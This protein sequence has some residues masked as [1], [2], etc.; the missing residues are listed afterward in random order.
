MKREAEWLEVRKGG[1]FEGIAKRYGILPMTARLIVNRS[2]ADDGG[3][4][5]YLHGTKL[6]DPHR[7]KDMDK[8]VAL[9]REKIRAGK[10]I[11]IIGDYDIDGIN[12]TY[13]LLKGLRRVGG[14]CDTAIPD[15][16][17][18][19]YG[20]NE[21]LM[22]AA[23][24]EGIDTI[25]TCDNGISAADAVRHGKELGLT[26]IVTDHHDIPYVMAAGE[27]SFRLP[28]A[29]AVV[30]PKQ[31]DCPY[32]Y[33]GLCGAVVAWKLVQVLYEAFGIPQAEADVFYENA[34]FATIGDVMDLT[35]ENR[36]IVREG[37]KALRSTVNPGMKALILQSGIAPERIGTYHVGFILGPCINA[38][39]R[40]DTAGRSLALL[41]SENE[42]EAAR[43]AAD[44]V[45]LNE[46][47]KEMTR[48]GVL[49]A[50]ELI[51]REKLLSEKVLVVYLPDCHESLAGI[52][53]GRLRE[54]YHRPVFVLTRGEDGIK[55]SG[56]SIEEYSM[57]D[58]L[59]GVSDLL[60][61]Y[62][63]HPMA[64]GLSMQEE[65]LPAFIRRINETC[66]LTQDDLREKKRF[67]MVLPFRCVSER[68]VQ[69]I[70]L[71]EPF[72]KGNAK[73]LFAARDVYIRS[74]RVLGKNGN[75]LK[76]LLEEGG[77]QLDG[78]YFGDPEVFFSRCNEKERVSILYYPELNEFRGTVRMQA[79]ISDVR[80]T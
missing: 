8:A 30:N 40:L 33:R 67:D 28:P 11:R 53:A 60:L 27:K 44:L 80:G 31:S 49:E 46:S 61:K 73:P 2:V 17:K 10:R 15:R 13:I 14:D 50:E 25:V 23:A 68:F 9:L 54:S 66:R 48:R 24:A 12:A 20:I 51:Q 70:A 64:A 52:I 1:D 47:R 34:A 3:I 72:G 45:A 71:L 78:I 75:V 58:A 35:G 7:M 16:E 59:T 57:Y 22:D 55:G 41:L 74:S 26:V 62:G 5:D 39:G 65:N 18:D 79:V 21:H 56:R 4:E 32:P 77:V 36:T 76:L 43:T 37:L 63:G 29:D 69:E 6:F 19:G 42:G 38:S